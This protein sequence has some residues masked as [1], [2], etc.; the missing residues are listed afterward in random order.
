[1]IV[2]GTDGEDTEAQILAYVG[3]KSYIRAPCRIFLI[4][5]KEHI[6]SVLLLSVLARI[7]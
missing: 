7:F 6:S 5:I 3:A 4:H 2:L 1:M